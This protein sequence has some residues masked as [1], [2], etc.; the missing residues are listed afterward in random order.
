[1]FKF[2]K[3]SFFL[4]FISSSLALQAQKPIPVC[5]LGLSVS[6]MPN[7]KVT[8]PATLLDAGSY[9]PKFAIKNLKIR[10]QTPAPPT[11]TPYDPTKASDSLTFSCIG[12]QNAVLW[13]GNPDGLWEACP[14]YVSI[15]NDFQVKNVPS[16][17]PIKNDCPS[18]NDKKVKIQFGKQT[19][20]CMGIADFEYLTTATNNPNLSVL[21]WNKVLNNSI[22]AANGLFLNVHV[23]NKFTNKALLNGVSTLDMVLISKHILGTQPLTS[24]YVK[25]AADINNNGTVTTADL[26]AL[27]KCILGI[28]TAF[29]NNT[30]WKIF[31][32]D[33]AIINNNYA[34]YQI[35]SDS[36][37]KYIAV[38]IGDINSS[39]SCIPAAPRDSKTHLFKVEEKAL[40][41]DDLYILNIDNQ[42][43][44]GFQ[45]TL[46]YDDTALEL[47]GLDENSAQKGSGRIVTSQLQ[48]EQFKATFKAKKQINIS[49]AIRI[50]SSKLVAEAYMNDEIFIVDF[51]FTKKVNNDFSIGQNQP[52]PFKESTQITFT[53]PQTTDY[54]L[55]ISD[56][57]GREVQNIKSIA[58]KGENTVEVKIQEKDIYF[59]QLK[60]N[61]QLAVKKMIV[62]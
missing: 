36:T 28:D 49:E 25:I 54:Q 31:P 19:M 13:V 59:Y 5:F 43:L 18:P 58:Q 11:G 37:L 60:I 30:S 7:G 48:G 44:D 12:F 38:K 27:R 21:K 9:D 3:L 34:S 56:A 52:N 50:S 57:L 8:I 62:E 17:T 10:A 22:C 41:K 4:L 46:K 61:G 2:T 1:M 45:F 55:I 26:L 6:I 32:P 16:C 33:G 35:K 24:K 20:D 29:Q 47:V 42:E 51:D 53:S 23:I 15:Q 40:I 14:T 39:A